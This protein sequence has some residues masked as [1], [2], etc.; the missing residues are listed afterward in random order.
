MSYKNLVN[1]PAVDKKEY[2]CRI[3]DFICARNGT[4]DYSTS[5]IGWTLLDSSYAVDEDNPQI[6]DWF[7][8]YSQGEDGKQDLYFKL[9]WVN[10][11]FSFHGYL[12]WDEVAHVGS[13]IRYGTITNVVTASESDDYPM[14]VYGDLNSVQFFMTTGVGLYYGCHFG[15]FLPMYEH[16]NGETAICSSALT[17]GSDVSITLDTI[18]SSWKVGREIFMRTTHKTPQNTQHVEKATIKTLVGNTITVDLTYDYTAN[19]KLT[20]HLGY[21]CPSSNQFFSNRAQLLDYSGAT[22]MS[23]TGA[24]VAGS[25]SSARDPDVYEDSWVAGSI[26]YSSTT[27]GMAGI[28]ENIVTIA[29]GTL[30]YEDVLEDN[31][32]VNWRFFKMYSNALIC[33]KEV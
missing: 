12:A 13:T 15:R 30:S 16:M 4:Y 26:H 25:S 22:N 20:D 2:F 17:A 14:W 1:Y 32:G 29:Q 31:E 18:P 33:I 19:S 9:T 23:S 21:F 5:G 28:A 3:R 8:I 6:N 10:E 11:Y 27:Y 7:V 24:L